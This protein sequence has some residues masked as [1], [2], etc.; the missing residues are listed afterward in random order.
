MDELAGL[1]A[2]HGC[3]F[4][5]FRCK[6]GQQ[7]LTQSDQPRGRQYDEGD[8]KEAEVEQPILG[9][10]GKIVAK[11]D[12]EESAQGGSQKGAHSPDDDHGKEFA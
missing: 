9:D 6:R 10:A 2:R 11:D 4:H 3:F 1:A 8:E 5:R 7:P 12:E